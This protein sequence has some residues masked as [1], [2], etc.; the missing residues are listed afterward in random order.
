MK[1]KAVAF[2]MDGTLYSSKPILA[3]AYQCAIEKLNS[4]KNKSYPAP[5]FEDIE[6]FIG[7]P[8]KF[9]YENLFPTMPQDELLYFGKVVI[10]EL[11]NAILTK[12]GE[13]FEGVPSVFKNL[14]EQGYKILIASNGRREYLQSILTKFNLN[15]AEE[16]ICVEEKNVKTKGDILKFYLDTLNLKPEEIV[17]VGDRSS[18]I[19]AAKDVNCIFIGCHFGHGNPNEIKDSDFDINNIKEVIGVLSQL[20]DD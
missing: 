19:N 14:K 5:A 17:M 8:V 13:L 16:F 12:G 11:E 1:I 2:D 4:E 3:Q 6:P 9:I 15:E 20:K 18:D 10:K 7:Q